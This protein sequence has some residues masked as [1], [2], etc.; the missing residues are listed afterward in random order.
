MC[1]FSQKTRHLV[2]LA[3]EGD[4]S[5][6]NQLYSVY[7]DRVRWMVRFRMSKELRSRLESMDLVQETLVHAISGLDKF[8]YSNEG[9]F[10]RWLS[11]IAENELRASLKKLHADKRDIRREVRLDKFGSSTKSRHVGPYGAIQ[12][13]TPSMVLS[14]KEDLAKLEKAIDQLKPEYREAIILTKIEGLSYQE[15]GQ[16]LG[17]SSD[18]VRML[19]TRAMAELTT[20]FGKI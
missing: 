15:I 20:I 6:L 1:N 11:K 4:Q 13:T 8:T 9:D 3:K 7:A 17:K 5:A 19:T 18:A 10:V 14:G 16:K 2:V 12:T